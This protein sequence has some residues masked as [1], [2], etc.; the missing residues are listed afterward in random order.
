MIRKIFKSKSA[1]ELKVLQLTPPRGKNWNFANS[2]KEYSKQFSANFIE[3]SFPYLLRNAR[4]LGVSLDELTL[5]DVGCGWAPMAV[6][7]VLYEGENRVD[8]PV[9][10]GYLGIDIRQDAID[11]LTRTYAKYSF[12]KFLL[13]E[14]VK[15]ADYISAQQNQVNTFAASEG[16]ETA[17][18]I[19]EHFTHNVQWSSSVF[20]HLTP[21]ACLQALKS[22]R[23]SCKDISLQVNTWLVI[24]KESKYS[25]ATGIADREL[26]FDCG[27]FLTYSKSNPLIC[28]AYKIEAI[29]EMYLDAGLEIVRIDRGSW[30][31]PFHK[32]DAHHYQDIIVSRPLKMAS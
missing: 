29:E 32:N 21:Q 23:R 13:H 17:F 31:G 9:P 4:E 12:V 1:T 5:L 20:T 25:L 27:D 14:T 19:P 3:Y 30:R 7:Y 22:I 8:R 2:E 11:W 18:K 10:V 26:P 16:G 15:E 6:P 28:T 24:D